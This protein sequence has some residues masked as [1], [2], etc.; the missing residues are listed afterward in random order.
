[1]FVKE[2]IEQILKLFNRKPYL[3]HHHSISYG[4]NQCCFCH[5]S[6]Y[7]HSYI[8]N[9]SS[10]VR[11]A[12]TDY[13]IRSCG[14]RKM[15][16]NCRKLVLKCIWSKSECSGSWKWLPRTPPSRLLSWLPKMFVRMSW[17][18]ISNVLKISSF[19]LYEN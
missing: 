10:A 11:G 2:Y 6:K 16:L 1:M 5:V 3:F 14:V 15:C 19:G 17:N 4:S 12:K 7:C 13:D 9:F 8:Q 18:R